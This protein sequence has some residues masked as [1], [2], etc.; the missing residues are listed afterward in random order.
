M[1]CSEKFTDRWGHVLWLSD[2][3]AEVGV[4]LDFGIRVVHLSCTGMENLFYQQP[5]DLS[6]GFVTPAGWRLY[7]GHRLWIA[8]ESD[9]TYYPDNDPVT[10]T[11]DA[12]SVLV[13]QQIDPVLKIRKQLRITFGDGTVELEHI[14]VNEADQPLTGA[15]WGVNTLAA[16]GTAHIGFPVTQPGDY[17]PRRVVSLWANTNLHDERVRFTKD[18]LTA[19]HKPSRDYFKI[20]LYC[21]PG[22]AVFENKGQRLTITFDALPL[23]QHPDNGCNFEL[24]MCDK[25]MELETLG[26]KRYL[27]PGEIMSHTETWQLS[28]L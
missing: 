27:Q 23:D 26:A 6:D 16:G 14:A 1:Q 19:W 10:Y 3:S 2:G 21:A 8:P 24:Y 28:K 4:A 11:Q 17:V 25:F 9:D 12:D 13:T 7:G 15:T 20:G 18:S 5:N 22:K